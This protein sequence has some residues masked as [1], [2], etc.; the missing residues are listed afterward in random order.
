VAMNVLLRRDVPKLGTTGEIVSVSEGYGRNYLLP[1]KLALEV[2][3]S[4]LQKIEGEKK[5]RTAREIQKIEELK[6]FADRIAAVDV[7]LKERVSAGDTLYGAVTPKEIVAALAEES[8]QIDPEM[9]QMPEPIKTLGVHR[10]KIR[11]HSQVT[12]ELKA[13]IVELKDADKGQANAK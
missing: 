3:P 11:L 9:V 5:Q 4:N 8:I 10:I 1:R 2:T 13:W 12:A 6:A 7:T